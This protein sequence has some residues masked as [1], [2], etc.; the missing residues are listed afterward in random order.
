M[1]IYDHDGTTAYE[2][3]KLYDY[4]G[5]TYSQQG[6]VYDYNGINYSLLYTADK[7]LLGDGIN[8]LF[9]KS[10]WPNWGTDYYP[11]GYGSSKTWVS[12]SNAKDGQ[13]HKLSF[14]RG[15]DYSWINIRYATSLF[16]REDYNTLRVIFKASGTRTRVQ[17]GIPE[18]G[19]ISG[20]LVNNTYLFDISNNLNMNDNEEYT[21][22][23]PVPSSF[24]SLM[25]AISIHISAPDDFDMWMKMY[26]E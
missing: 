23:I 7:T 2:I 17:I 4:D 20:S 3:G 24:S 10:N 6:K 21:V 5:T 19:K 26:L 8:V 25:L 13:W 9:A 16:S 14:R 11:T 15:G 22:T 12:A 18:N 1:A